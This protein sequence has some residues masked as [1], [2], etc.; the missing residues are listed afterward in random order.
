MSMNLVGKQN[1]QF[2]NRE[3]GEEIK[4]VKL[5]YTAPDDNVSG[6]AALTQFI[7]YNNALYNKAM[8]LSFGDF[9]IVYGRKGSVVDL[10]Q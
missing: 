6:M 7:N 4:G 9:M 1:V 5:H 3:T 8:N 2:V 10:I